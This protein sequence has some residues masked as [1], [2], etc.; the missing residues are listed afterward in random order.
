MAEY[1]LGRQMTAD[2]VASIITFLNALT[3][4][5]PA[6]YIRKPE[7]PGIKTKG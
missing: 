5:I 4:E 1:Q 6:E 3:G 7:L 2:E